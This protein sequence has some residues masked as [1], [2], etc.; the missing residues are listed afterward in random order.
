[1]ALWFRLLLRHERFDEVE[2]VLKR[3]PEL[4]ARMWRLVRQAFGITLAREGFYDVGLGLLLEA[5][6]AS[7]QDAEVYYWIGY[8]ALHR[9]QPEE[10]R[11]MWQTCLRMAEGHPLAQAG[12]SLLR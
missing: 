3:G 6:E 10:A 5:R 7:P 4:G 2:T 9:Q 12:L 8:C 1:M 11:L